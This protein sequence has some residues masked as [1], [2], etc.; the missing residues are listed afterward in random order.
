MNAVVSNYNSI[1]KLSVTTKLH[2]CHAFHSHLFTINDNLNDV[3]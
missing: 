2:L 1:F 3:I